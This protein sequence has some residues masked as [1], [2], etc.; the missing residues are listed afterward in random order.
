M[1]TY[2]QTTIKKNMITWVTKQNK[3][4]KIKR[5]VMS[6]LIMKRAH[7]YGTCINLFIL[8]EEVRGSLPALGGRQPEC[9]N[10][11]TVP[12]FLYNDR[13]KNNFWEKRHVVNP[14]SKTGDNFTFWHHGPMDAVQRNVCRKLLRCFCFYL[15]LPSSLASPSVLGLCEATQSC[16]TSRRR[17]PA[18]QRAKRTE[19][20]L[21]RAAASTAWTAAPESSGMPVRTAHAR[22]HAARGGDT[23]PGMNIHRAWAAP[24][25]A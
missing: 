16:M 10:L 13:E 21:W 18:T 23:P 9:S 6:V 11:R 7:I 1:A 17:P 20:R 4:G 14:R 15:P 12:G 19:R 24:C 3:K 25:A 5:N 2:L 8:K 22:R